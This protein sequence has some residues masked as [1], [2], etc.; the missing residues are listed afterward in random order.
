M[1]ALAPRVGLLT[2]PSPSTPPSRVRGS[3]ATA[4]PPLRL[5]TLPISLSLPPV[6][7]SRR[8]RLSLCSASIQLIFILNAI[9]RTMSQCRLDYTKKIYVPSVTPRTSDMAPCMVVSLTWCAPTLSATRTSILFHT[10][11]ISRP[12]NGTHRLC[13]LA[14]PRNSEINRLMSTSSWP[15]TTLACGQKHMGR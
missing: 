14:T 12:W 3:C 8:F 2:S 7:S 11:A 1:H 6:V 15:H 9:A 10:R 13:S 4:V 5:C